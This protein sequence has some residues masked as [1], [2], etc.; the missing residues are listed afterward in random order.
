MSRFSVLVLQIALIFHGNALSD[1]RSVSAAT[2]TENNR[3]VTLFLSGD[4]MLGRGIDQI[5]PYT[6]EAILYER[7]IKDARAYVTLAEEVNGPISKP[8]NCQYICIYARYDSRRL[9]RMSFS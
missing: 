4:V 5:L 3:T 7:Y 8:V 1:Q 6:T 2:G 9:N